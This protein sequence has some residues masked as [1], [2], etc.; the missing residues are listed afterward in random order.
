MTV[1]F[2]EVELGLKSSS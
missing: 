2:Y 1:Q